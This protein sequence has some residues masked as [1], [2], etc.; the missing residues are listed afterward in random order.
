M[1]NILTAIA[2]GLAAGVIDAAP[3]I[4]MK[5]EKRATISAFLHYFALGIV[6]PFV[7]WGIPQWSAGIIISMLSAIPIMIIVYPGDKKSIIPMTAF[8][9]ILGAAIGIAGSIF[10]I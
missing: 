2:I 1:H 8:S 9:I 4:I 3:M 10:I 5:L 6:I 7:N